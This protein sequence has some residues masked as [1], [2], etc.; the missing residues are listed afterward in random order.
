MRAF[1]ILRDRLRALLG[2]NVVVDE[3][4]EE[5]QFHLRE[6]IGE[7]ER[8]GLSPDAARQAALRKFGSPS[9]MQDL[10]YEVRGGGVMETI[11]QDLRYSVRLL[12]K[13]PGFSL[14]AILTLAFGIGA[15]TAIF[16]VID[17][18]VLRPLPFAE[19]E[20]LVDVTLSMQTQSGAEPTTAWPSLGDGHYWREHGRTITSVGSMRPPTLQVVDS[21]AGPERVLVGTMGDGALRMFGVV[22]AA[23]REF[24]P[25]EVMPNSSPAVLL[26]HGYWQTRFQ[27]DPGVVGKVVRFIDGP[28]AVVGVVPDNFYRQTAVWRAYRIPAHLRV[29]RTATIARLRPGVSLDDAAKE[30]TDLIGRA[31][32][33]R[34][35]RGTVK[36]VLTSLHAQSTSG[37][38]PTVTTLSAAVGFILLIACVNVAGLLLARG[39][40]RRPEL[41]IRASIGASRSRLMRQLLTES[42]VLAV[43]GGGLG[44]LFAWLFLDTLVALIPMTLPSTAAATLNPQVLA[45]ALALSAATAVIF[46]L[47]PA[48]KLSR[49]QLTAGFGG[50]T[51]R[52]GSALSRRGGQ[53]L[54]GV[55]VALAV[56]LLTAAGLMVR[57]FSR[58][59]V[60]DVGFDPSK[61]VTMEVAPLEQTTQVMTP[62]YP[63]LLDAVRRVPGVLSAGAVDGLPMFTDGLA[64]VEVEGRRSIL[65]RKQQ[66]SSGYIESMGLRIKQGRAPTDADLASGRPIV[67]IN[68]RLAS[69]LFPGD[70]AAGRYL[71]LRVGQEKPQRYEIVAVVGNVRRDGPLTEPPMEVLVP[72]M[73]VIPRPMTV[74]I[75]PGLGVPISSDHLR[76]TALAVGPKVFIER[77]RVG[78]DYLDDKVITPRHSTWLFSLL[79]GLGLALTLVGIFGTTAYAVARRTQEIGIRMAFG[80]RPGQVVKDVVTDAAWPVAI[81]TG[82]G[83][84]GA[85]FSTRI[86]EKFLFQTSPTDPLTFASVA[87]ILGIAACVAA[88]LPARRA[89]A[90][91]PV[92]ALRAE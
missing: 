80:A 14:I 44:A 78:S 40:T 25:D 88:W 30:L 86:I 7:H 28:A 23:G 75:R 72:S 82:V 12:R 15:S 67:V 9:V 59:M 56:V 61:I 5:I 8:R 69:S 10:S 58:V 77:I 20:Q 62:F 45:F 65:V 1:R 89:A 43:A 84:V 19:P 37:Y 11:G 66:G 52:H 34:G 41:A 2:R 50:G 64:H 90:V 24:S 87:I 74:V 29:T 73:Q 22:P 36:A 60:V 70:A 85:F 55:E 76:Q 26:G 81:G 71:M 83:L 46:G 51:R 6:R 4:H 49:V 54:I 68:E 48:V 42:L 63:A 39:A 21:G 53:L 27:G 38:G 57:S 35:E 92:T 16:S 17:A 18:S 91:D 31:D 13:Q 3:I 79:G 47:I 32:A 33:D